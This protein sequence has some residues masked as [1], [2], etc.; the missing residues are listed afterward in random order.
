MEGSDKDELRFDGRKTA[1][2]PASVLRAI[3]D[4]RK[5]CEKKQWVLFT[6]KEGKQVRVR[7]V[8][9]KV[10]GWVDQFIRI[11]DAAVQYDPAHAALPWAGVRL[12]LQVPMNLLL[13]MSTI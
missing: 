6:N 11:E 12:L 5:E 13:N 7:D 10:S 8:V 1:T 9:D 3:A 2:D 4:K